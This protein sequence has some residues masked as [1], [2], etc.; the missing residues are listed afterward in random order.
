MANPEPRLGLIGVRTA[1]RRLL[2]TP[3]LPSQ[4]RCVVAP[5]L[6]FTTVL[7]LETNRVD[8]DPDVKDASGLPAMCITS[9]SHPDD[10]HN[11]EFCRQQSIEIMEAVGAATV[12]APPLHRGRAQPGHRRTQPSDHDDPGPRVPRG[13]TSRTLRARRGRMTRALNALPRV[14]VRG[15]PSPLPRG[16]LVCLVL[17]ALPAAGAAQRPYPHESEAIGTAREI[18]DGALS[19]EMAVNT[20]RNIHRLFPSRWIPASTRPRPLPQATEPLGPITLDDD[21]ERYDLD[22]FMELNRVAAAL[23]LKDGQ[24]K[25]ERYRY[26]NTERTRW[27]SM[28]VAKSVTSTLFGAALEDGRVLSLEG[29]GRWLRA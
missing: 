9:Q 3:T 6:G 10:I 2:H 26:G 11:M 25:L 4:R 27:M 21:G 23:V 16:V 5:P 18:Y 12:W 20:F 13:G 15:A 8:L 22:E 7:P 17:L 24:V 19:P 29:S 28:S 1:F 14:A